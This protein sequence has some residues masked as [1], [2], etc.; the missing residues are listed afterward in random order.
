MQMCV[1]LCVLQSPMPK[2]I[3]IPIPISKSSAPRFRNSV[4]GL[5]QEIERIIIRDA[6]EKD[7]PIVVSPTDRFKYCPHAF[8]MFSA[9][10]SDG[11]IRS[12]SL[13][14]RCFCDLICVCRVFN[15][16]R[17]SQMGTAHPHPSPHSA[18]AAPAASTHRRPLGVA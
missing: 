5:N 1:Y 18:A 2:T 16:P 11:G 14:Q 12:P 4:E 13:V 6:P 3:L 7:E 9:A 15:S 10:V 8:S 17:T